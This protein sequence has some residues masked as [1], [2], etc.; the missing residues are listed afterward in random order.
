[1]EGT[2]RHSPLTQFTVL[3]QSIQ[4]E[5]SKNVRATTAEAILVWS[6]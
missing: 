6:A 4:N 5:V 3:E 2:A 1:M